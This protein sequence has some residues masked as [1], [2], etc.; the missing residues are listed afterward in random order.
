MDNSQIL[1]GGGTKQV[2]LQCRF[3]NRHGLI[4]GATGTGKTVTM[5]VLAEQ[6]SLAGVPVFLADVKGD[7]SGLCAAA[8]TS[9]KLAE[10]A[11]KVGAEPYTPAA[12]P[13]VFW[14]VFG[15]QGHPVRTTVSE[16]GPVLLTQMLGLNDTQEGI[17][18]IAFRVADEQG[19][20][21]LDLADLRSLLNLVAS[22]R[23]ALSEKYGLVSPQSVAAIQRRLLVLEEQGIEHFLGEPALDI[24]DLMRQDMSGRGLINVLVSN[25]LFQHPRLYA[26]CLLWLL[27]ELFEEL[28]EVGD[29]DK[30]RLVF[31]FDEAHV[32]FGDG[33]PAL[34]EQIEKVVRLIRSKGIGVFFVTQS[35]LDLPDAVLGQLGNRVQHALRAFTPRDQKAVRAA[36]QTFRTNPQLDTGTVITELGVGE[37]L[38]STLEDKGIPGIVERCLIRPPLSKIG[39]A[40]P[41]AVS[42]MRLR[43]PVG[44]RYDHRV[45]RESAYEV[46]ARRA[47]KA[48]ED[49]ETA[50]REAAKTRTKPAGRSRQS[51]GEAVTKSALRSI[52]SQ[53]G[54]ALM[55]GIL[56]ALQKR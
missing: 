41:E 42:S 19:L 46:L 17:L 16:L 18:N 4:A 26:V 1:I 20:L 32:L 35:P 36:A 5:Q 31:F 47:Q 2:F 25:K 14:D 53:L 10:R 39:P 54:R 23:Q 3:A 34:E 21:L 24:R 11:E 7:L 51:Y 40:E 30:P 48:L 44:G 28:P 45:D 13:V 15:E 43:S 33:S 9:P 52:G 29:P 50:Q 6:F 37:A 22:E 8:P 55:R 38:V 27:A 56:G 12:A 49:T